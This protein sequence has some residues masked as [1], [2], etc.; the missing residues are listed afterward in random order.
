MSYLNGLN[1]STANMNIHMKTLE[2]STM[3][4]PRTKELVA[5]SSSEA[6]APIIDSGLS[7]CEESPSL[8]D[9]GVSGST[10]PAMSA[11]TGGNDVTKMVQF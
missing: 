4:P 10:L 9:G 7:G 5:E 3:P 2:L 11:A 8:D 1:S 6:L